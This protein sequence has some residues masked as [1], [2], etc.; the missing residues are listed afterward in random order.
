MRSAP[1]ATVSTPSNPKTAAVVS[2]PE[3]GEHRH[4]HR[5]ADLLGGDVAKPD[6]DADEREEE[7]ESRDEDEDEGGHHHPGD[8]E[9]DPE[10]PRDADDRD[11]ARGE[12]RPDDLES[13]E[14][15][16]GEHRERGEEREEGLP[17]RLP[18]RGEERHDRA[19]L[20]PRN[21]VLQ[22]VGHDDAR[23]RELLVDVLDPLERDSEVAR[24]R[25]PEVRLLRSYLLDRTLH[26]RR[27]DHLWMRMVDPYWAQ[28]FGGD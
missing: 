23:R 17:D 13:S 6:V 18:V 2:E 24:L 12:Q 22:G 27:A 19:L 11:E 14:R 16:Q 1:V 10:L 5:E 7:R 4:G 26:S 3:W 25:V 28:H 8:P 9:R 15:R 21:E 20:G